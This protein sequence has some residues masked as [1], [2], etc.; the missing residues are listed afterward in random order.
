ML[1]ALD[2]WYGENGGLVGLVDPR[3]ELYHVEF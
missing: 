2:G 3:G 1:A